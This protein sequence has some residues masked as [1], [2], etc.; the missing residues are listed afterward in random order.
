MIH[1]FSSFRTSIRAINLIRGLNIG[2]TMH[3]R[4]ISRRF[5]WMKKDD[6]YY[7]QYSLF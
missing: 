4:L 1:N 3:S 2:L 5:V 7:E 6:V